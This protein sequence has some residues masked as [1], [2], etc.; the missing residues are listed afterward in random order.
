MYLKKVEIQGF[1]S[2]ADKTEI[3]FKNEVTAIVGP[4]GSGKSNI[5]DA[6]RWVL[7]EQSIKSL[8]GSKM[9]DV[10]F[11]GTDSRR[12]L[13]YAEV[14][15]TFN[16]ESG[17]IPIDY[18][19]V[20]VTRR[21]FRSGESEFYINKN[22][23][24]LKD[25]R[26]L[27][28]DSGI[29]KDGYSIIGQGRI[30]EIL[31]NRPEDRR[32]IFEEAAGIIK[33]RSKKEEAERK[34]EKTEA[35]IVRIKDLIYEVSNQK[36]VLQ[37]E[38]EKAER[39]TKLYGRLRYLEVNLFIREVR[40]LEQQ[41][42]DAR[43]E[44][45]KLSSDLSIIE[46]EKNQIEGKYNLLKSNIENM[47]K[48]I[49]DSRTIKF[50]RIQAFESNRNGLNLLAEKEGFLKKDL[51]RLKQEKEENSKNIEDILIFIDDIEVKLQELEI[52]LVS[53]INERNKKQEE[54][55]AYD[56]LVLNEEAILNE[57]KNN[58]MSLFNSASDKK[59]E[60]NSIKSLKLNNS[61]R[62]DELN[63]ESNLYKDK[64]DNLV[65]KE[66]ELKEENN[67]LFKNLEEEKGRLNLL[68][69]DRTGIL[70]ELGDI[71]KLLRSQQMK[72]NGLQTNFNLY[73]NME[74]SYEGYYKSIKTLIK[75][76]EVDHTFK[77]GFVGI[78][79]DLLSVE[80][81]YSKAIDISLGSSAQNVVVETEMDAKKFVGF[82]KDKKA[83]RA[84]FLPLSV[85]KGK[86][87]NLD[88]RLKE[89]YN[90]LGLGHELIKYDK[91]YKEI[92]EFLLGRTIIVKDMDSGIRLA[93][94]QGHIYRIVTLDGEV[95]NSGGSITGGS[96]GNESLSLIS[97]KSKLEELKS[98]IIGLEKEI[99]SSEDIRASIIKKSE[100]IESKIN[101]SEKNIKDIDL[102]T[103]QLNNSIN[104]NANEIKRINIDLDKNRLEMDSLVEETESFSSNLMELET[105][106]DKIQKEIED[107]KN[108]SESNT[109]KISELKNIRDR[110]NKDLTELII[111]IN[112]LENSKL[113]LQDQLKNHLSTKDVLNSGQIEKDRNIRSIEDEINSISLKKF[114]LEEQVKLYNES[115]E[116]LSQKLDS[117]IQKKDNYMKTFYEEQDRLKIINIRISELEKQMGALDVKL[118]R[119]ELQ[120]E[121]TH[122]RL[123]EDYE[124][125]F[126]D[127]VKLERDIESLQKAQV[128]VRELKEEIKSIGNVN[129]SS[130]EEYKNICERY[131][132]ITNQH[133]DLIL[134]KDNL[135]EVI[136][137]MEK[138]MRLQFVES[139]EEINKNFAE[140]FSC[141]FNGGKGSLEL[142]EGE[143]ILKSGIEIKVQPPGKKLQ[144]LSLLSGGEKSL[145]AVALLFAILRTKP[146]PFCI[147]DEIDAALD[148]ANISRY[149]NYLK[150]IND[151]T[152]FILITHRK[153][154][155]EI[156]DVLYGVTMEEEGVSKLI[157]IKLKSNLVE[158]S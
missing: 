20:A 62:I 25:I 126:E 6:I 92:F 152:Q 5:S 30:E 10:I 22:S 86:T 123:I 38:S 28:M 143:D 90:I 42:K 33:F 106:F 134:S 52:N 129:I 115:E 56:E 74:S 41:I 151:N 155:M 37:G 116:E 136:K 72:L 111:Q 13:G 125:T 122:T 139:F 87:I 50:D 121:N 154:T 118:A 21:M 140:V 46:E 120:L 156:A 18:M 3:E 63:R 100:I 137:D 114:D 109:T 141:L 112:G 95:L 11:A 153:T 12:A 68:N 144:T 93:G 131:E 94:K 14:T 107:V 75:N 147:L 53:L 158:A 97:R 65:L 35:N 88:A 34:L 39:F 146:S 82:L 59:T 150:S 27:F 71:D 101:T 132:F 32:N 4:N 1:K 73:S 24:R 78:V 79:A 105:A 9:E 36:D 19:E 157:S 83:G 84:T 67:E 85:I 133:E 145:T 15:I 110:V 81:I 48:E 130:I 66:N 80:S 31:S 26:E 8:R 148:E 138:Q 76:I 49:E 89:E 142:E 91:N 40:K 60:I 103:I 7:G 124:L 44:K 43:L 64:L 57:D 70:N 135:R 108:R 119:Y 98:E 128:E 96:F 2:F 47:E 113:S 55:K 16:N 45:E 77:K 54:L 29:G 102:K 149:T 61:K 51:I 127:A 104:L 69:K 17:M 23:C 99:L 58:I 117:L